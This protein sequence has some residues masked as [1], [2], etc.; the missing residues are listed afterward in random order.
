MTNLVFSVKTKNESQ[1]IEIHL[2][3]FTKGS[4]GHFSD[5]R[6]VGFL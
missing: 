6:T 3:A 4:A 5:L 2:V 1:M